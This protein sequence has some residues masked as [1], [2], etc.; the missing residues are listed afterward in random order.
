MSPYALLFIFL[1]A[2]V[3][4]VGLIVGLNAFLGP[5]P[6]TSASAP[7]EENCIQEQWGIAIATMLM[8]F[9]VICPDILSDSS[10]RQQ[11]TRLGTAGNVRM[12]EIRL[13]S[14]NQSAPR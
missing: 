10:I 5:R 14:S 4:L 1:L 7:R 3:G 13:S 2:A 9:S 12:S 8:L 6:A 11:Q